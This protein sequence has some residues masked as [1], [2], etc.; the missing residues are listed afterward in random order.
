[1]WQKSL[2]NTFCAKSV[3]VIGSLPDERSETGIK[4]IQNAIKNAILYKRTIYNIKKGHF[5]CHQ[6]LAVEKEVEK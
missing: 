5:C 2:E 1:M 6:F 4:L 3:A